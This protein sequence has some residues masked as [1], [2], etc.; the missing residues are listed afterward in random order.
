MPVCEHISV[1]ACRAVCSACPRCPGLTRRP[2]RPRYSPLRGAPETPQPSFSSLVGLAAGEPDLW[3]PTVPGFSRA[4]CTAG[5]VSSQ[6]PWS[7][8]GVASWAE[9]TRPPPPGGATQPLPSAARV[10][11]ATS[12]VSSCAGHIHL[13]E[14]FNFMS[15]LPHYLFTPYYLD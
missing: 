5:A 7:R 6:D 8:V 1:C 10:A 3:V 4:V 14:G 13:E 2:C 11:A 15:H 9:G 12:T